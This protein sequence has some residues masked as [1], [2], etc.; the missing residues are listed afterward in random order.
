M[1][2]NQIIVIINCSNRDQLV[3]NL[4]DRNGISVSCNNSLINFHFHL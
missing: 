4:P 3:K 1:I 2:Y